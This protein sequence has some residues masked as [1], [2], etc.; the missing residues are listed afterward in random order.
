MRILAR[1]ESDGCTF[2]R[3][4]GLTSPGHGRD[5]ERRIRCLY[6]FMVTCRCPITSRRAQQQSLFLFFNVKIHQLAKTLQQYSAS[7]C[8]LDTAPCRRELSKPPQ[9]SLLR[10]TS[11]P[12]LVVRRAPV[13]LLSPVCEV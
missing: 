5:Q 11:R 3:R 4:L 13:F 12:V 9:K 8:K 2:Y 7:V 6:F 10:G 1:S